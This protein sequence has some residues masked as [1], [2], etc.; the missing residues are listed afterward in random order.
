MTFKE[1][2]YETIGS[3]SGGARDHGPLKFLDSP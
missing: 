2:A 1:D 3:G